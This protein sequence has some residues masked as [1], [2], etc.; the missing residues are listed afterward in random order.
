MQTR[1]SG[2]VVPP[3]LYLPVKRGDDTE[4]SVV[5]MPVAG[6][7]S[8]LLA[9]TAL[10]RL[11]SG[12]GEGQEWTLIFTERLP[13]LVQQAHFDT[14]AFDVNFPGGLAKARQL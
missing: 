9:Y 12:C 8:A 7:R 10:D 1:P 2:P 5:R 11:A 3:V 13:E 4:V 14:I 6:G